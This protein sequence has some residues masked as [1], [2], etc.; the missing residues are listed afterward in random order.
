VR[1]V[2]AE[3][4]R[5]KQVERIRVE[6]NAR[7]GEILTPEQK[8]A[9]ERLLAEA[10]SRGAAASGRVYV[11]ENAQP[12]ALEVRLGL[13]DGTS[14]EVLA[15]VDEGAE[16]IVGMEGARAGSQPPAGGLPRARFF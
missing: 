2:R 12:K 8:P 16:V 1:D 15:G 10:G 6:T 13:T 5:R 3:G 14:T 9:W 11:L 7:I 4:E